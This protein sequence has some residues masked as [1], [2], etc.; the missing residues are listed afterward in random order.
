MFT[1]HQHTS[2]G[3]TALWLLPVV[4]PITI[5]AVG[6]SLCKL[7]IDRER[8]EYALTIM[9]TSYVMNGVGL[10]LACGIMIIYF[11]RLAL[12]HLPPK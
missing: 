3:L 4:P 8:Y 6:S 10:L 11:N 1:K 7:L 2:E 5:A 12:H 9:I